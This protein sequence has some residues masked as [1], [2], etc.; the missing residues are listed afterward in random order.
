MIVRTRNDRIGDMGSRLFIPKMMTYNLKAK[1]GITPN[2]SGMHEANAN[3]SLVYHAGDWCA[4]YCTIDNR[5]YNR[6]CCFW[7]ALK[8]L[9]RALFDTFCGGGGVVVVSGMLLCVV[10]QLSLRLMLRRMTE[11]LLPKVLL[12][13]CVPPTCCLWRLSFPSSNFCTPHLFY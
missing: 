13:P 5:S 12:R 6:R 9:P 1:L 3:T 10:L 7:Q 4:Y 11:S 8:N 2:F